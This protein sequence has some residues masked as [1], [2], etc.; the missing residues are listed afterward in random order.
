MVAVSIACGPDSCL[1]L[2]SLVPCQGPEPITNTGMTL[3]SMWA[4]L[5]D[6]CRRS[7]EMTPPRKGQKVQKDRGR[8]EEGQRKDRGRTEE[9]HRK[10]RRYSRN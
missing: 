10:D 5:E 9:G 1:D 8:T 4:R 3:H 7:K 6:G 2:L